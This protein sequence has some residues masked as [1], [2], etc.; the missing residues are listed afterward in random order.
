MTFTG[1]RG[2]PAIVYPVKGIQ[3]VAY[4]NVCEQI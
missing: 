4:S 2:A 1:E 3:W